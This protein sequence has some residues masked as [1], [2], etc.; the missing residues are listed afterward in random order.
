[1]QQL[2]EIKQAIRHLVGHG[3]DSLHAAVAGVAGD[4][5]LGY[6]EAGRYALAV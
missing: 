6:V 4:V 3:H 5:Q 2:L 1:M